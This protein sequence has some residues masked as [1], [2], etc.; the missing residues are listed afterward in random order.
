MKTR[1]LCLFGT[2]DQFKRKK[3]PHCFVNIFDIKNQLIGAN[4][5]TQSCVHVQSCPTL[6]D[7]NG[8]Q[9]T[10]LLCPWGF[11]SKNTG[12]GCHFL[13]QGIFATQGSNPCLLCRLYWQVDS[14]PLA[15]P[16]CLPKCLSTNI[17]D[18]LSSKIHFSWLTQ[19]NH[20]NK[21][22]QCRHHTFMALSD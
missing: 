3:N 21:V 19:W 15:P 17:K 5:N 9:P 6:C 8:L 7:S 22:V 4:Q 1:T 13:L 14:L 16:G 2:L 10:R 11:P 18:I 12:V 20:N